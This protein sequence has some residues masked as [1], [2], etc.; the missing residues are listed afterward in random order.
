MPTPTEVAAT[1]SR[2]RDLVTDANYTRQEAEA[3][4]ARLAAAGLDDEKY[5]AFL[6]GY[7]FP[8][9]GAVVTTQAEPNPNGDYGV[10][11]RWLSEIEPRKM[12]YLWKPRLPLGVLTMYDGDPEKAKSTTMLDLA[13]R[14]SR[15]REFPDGQRLVEPFKTVIL[16]AED[17]AD[18]VIRPRFD[19]FGGDPSMVAILDSVKQVKNGP[20]VAAQPHRRLA[21]ARSGNP[22][23]QATH[24]CHR[25]RNR[26][27][28]QG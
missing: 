14:G 16:S 10:R 9:G 28:R 27:P 15:G 7:D 20:P 1:F 3:F 5:A 8:P 17:P 6:R 21:S 13:A 22:G 24:G 25:P 4:R 2:W 19:E 18:T 26:L 11:R 23:R 12:E